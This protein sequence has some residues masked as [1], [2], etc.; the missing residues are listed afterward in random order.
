M[1]AINV[2]FTANFASF[3]GALFKPETSI[4]IV[5]DVGREEFTIDRLL[6]IGYENI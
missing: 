3:V 2:S 1:G 4:V 6:R 5:A